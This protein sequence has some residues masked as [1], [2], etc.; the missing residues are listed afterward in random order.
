MSMLVE[1]KHVNQSAAR[2][3]SDKSKMKFLGLPWNQAKRILFEVI[4]TVLNI[5]DSDGTSKRP[6]ISEAE[7]ETNKR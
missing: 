1:W 3:P 7:P 6:L 4:C 2:G 5:E